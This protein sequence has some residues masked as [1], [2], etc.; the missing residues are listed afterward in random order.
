MPLG[1]K[2]EVL[3]PFLQ[4]VFP[5]RFAGLQELVQRGYNIEVRLARIERYLAKLVGEPVVGGAV[6]EPQ[7]EVMALTPA[8]LEGY[9]SA[10]KEIVK[11]NPMTDSKK[12]GGLDLFETEEEVTELDIDGYTAKARKLGLKTPSGNT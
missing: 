4:H 8:G 5:G 11:L 9:M 2:L 3:R 7:D 12:A 6:V 10:I 1:L